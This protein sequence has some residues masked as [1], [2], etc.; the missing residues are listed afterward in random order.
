LE[1]SLKNL[2]KSGNFCREDREKMNVEE[3]LT[4]RFVL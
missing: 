4:D 3:K 2:S 1:E